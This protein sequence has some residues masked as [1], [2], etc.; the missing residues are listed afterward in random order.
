MNARRQ[1]FDIAARL[2]RGTVLFVALVFLILLTLLAVTATGTSIMQERMT[3]SM[4][5]G[6]L[7]L[8]G[9][10]SALRGA[11]FYIWNLSEES[12]SSSDGLKMYCGYEGL[13]GCYKRTYG[14]TKSTVQ[15]FRKAQGEIPAASDGGIAYTPD[16]SGL[17][18]DEAS[19]NL[20]SQPR[21]LIEDIG[22]D[23][24]P[25]TSG[26]MEGA[27]QPEGG[28][29]DTD[30]R[31]VYRITARSHGG[32]DAVVRITESSFVA[33]APKSVNPDE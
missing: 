31:R 6:Q 27:R 32:S 28:V 17:S 16:L 25:G 4:R 26:R 18:G 15:V 19:A 5:N 3:G 23:K 12:R 1:G 8:M 13:L 14:K 20:A 9:S 33:L 24:M 2:Q 29:D 10:E 21:Y 30:S 7:G 22:A 11:E